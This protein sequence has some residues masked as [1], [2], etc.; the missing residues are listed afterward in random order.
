MDSWIVIGT[1]GH[2][3]VEM[4]IVDAKVDIRLNIV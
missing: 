1:N 4:V 2:P 3:H